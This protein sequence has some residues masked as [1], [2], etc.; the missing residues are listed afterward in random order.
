MRK[1]KQIAL[2]VLTIALVFSCMIP[3]F[4]KD[5]PPRAPLVTPPLLLSDK[6]DY[7]EAAARAVAAQEKGGLC[8]A[9]NGEVLVTIVYPDKPSEILLEAALFLRDTLAQM[10]GDSDVQA[11]KESSLT[12]QTNLIV[13]GETKLSASVKTDA[14]T[15]DGYRILSSGTR[16]YIKGA[17]QPG[18]EGAANGVYGFLEDYLECM[19]ILHDASYIPSFPDIYLAPL[20]AVSNPSVPWRRFFQKETLL[21]SWCRR[22]RN[23]GTQ[24][25]VGENEGRNKGWGTW[26]HNVFLYV[27]PEI[28]FKEHPEYFALVD[29]KREYQFEQD[30]TMHGGQLCLT[31]PDIIPI[32][33]ASLAKMIEKNPEALYWDFSINDNGRHCQC[34]ACAKVLQETGSM[35]GTMLPVINEL[36]RAFPDKIISTLAY[37]YNSDPPRGVQCEEN[38]NIVVAPIQAGQLYDYLN[39]GIEKADQTKAR[40]KGWAS[41]SKRLYIWD[42]VINF[43]NLLMPFPNF[44]VQK[45]NLE[46]YLQNNVKAIFHQGSREPGDEMA[47]LRPYI[48]SRQ[49]WD[50][51]IDINRVMGKYLVVTYGAAAPYIAEYLE[52]MTRLLIEKAYD[53]DISQS[54]WDHRD[55]YLSRDAI[56][57][58][59]KLME[60]A[61]KAVENDYTLT[62]RV[63]R[64][65]VNVLYAKMNEDS[66]D[67]KGKKAAHEE[68]KTLVRRLL[69]L[70]P[71]E[72]EPPFMDD[73]VVDIYPT[74]L[75]K[76]R[77]KFIASIVGISLGALLVIA[78][79]TG[80]V[81]CSKKKKKKKKAA[82]PAKQKAAEQSLES[83]EN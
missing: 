63:L 20:D 41:V 50:K 40:L 47:G 16:L 80:L 19:F 9:K 82:Q 46:F 34:E 49:M 43:S 2:L 13:L 78:L 68:F 32:A 8:L 4:S 70:K 69:I 27:D 26:C 72:W 35:M 11:I 25:M 23:N 83:L 59:Q 65:K 66:R 53:L 30:G 7:N 28:Y 67:Y 18:Q 51:D 3:A 64:V 54:V 33:K 37:N 74:Q 29:G 15:D 48:F 38:V 52:T 75:A 79:P 62:E 14:V 77:N 22:L 17:N 36:A 76:E 31:N 5:A 21:N 45:N 81:L 57:G 39:G 58:Y 24:P 42:Y 56:K 61:L 60:K 6:L 55:D 71:F 1:L 10:T 12:G 44:T 73:Y